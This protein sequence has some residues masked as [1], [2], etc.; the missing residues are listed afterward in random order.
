[1]DQATLKQWMSE[2]K[3][4]GKEDADGF[5]TVVSG[6]LEISVGYVAEANLVVCFAS[7]LELTGLEDAQ[8]IEALSQSLALNG[9]GSL[10]PGCAVSYEDAGDVVFLLWQQ[11]PEQLDSTR[12][13]NAF[14]DFETAAAQVQGHLRGLLSDS[15]SAAGDYGAPDSVI[16]V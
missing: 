10:P 3:L 8:R 4:E 5:L 15:A 6:N 11:S 13:E 12:F 7:L 16:K 1:M 9:V 14:R 2:A